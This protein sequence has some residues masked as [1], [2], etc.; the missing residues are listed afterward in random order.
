MLVRNNQIKNYVEGELARSLKDIKDKF[1]LR[2]GKGQLGKQPKEVIEDLADY[3]VKFMIQFAEC[4]V[5]KIDGNSSDRGRIM[6]MISDSIYKDM[7]IKDEYRY[8]LTRTPENKNYYLA[9]HN[10][11]S[12]W[13]TYLVENA[14]IQL[15][16]K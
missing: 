11:M 16:I 2:Q 14:L 3:E 15:N 5:G 12:S 6:R 10:I 1:R 7:R 13:K 9:M 4:F 8:T